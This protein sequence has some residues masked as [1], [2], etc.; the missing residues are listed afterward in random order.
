[1]N[2][3]YPVQ[4]YFPSNIVSAIGEHIL[5]SP[6]CPYLPVWQCPP[7]FAR[8]A[9]FSL[10]FQYG[11][12]LPYLTDWQCFPYFSVW[13]C[14][15]IFARLAV[16]SHVCHFGSV[17]PYFPDWQG[18]PMF[19]SLVVSSH[20]CQTGSDIPYLPVWQCPLIFAS[21]VVSSHICRTGSDLL[22]GQQPG[23]DLLAGT[24]SS[25]AFNLYGTYQMK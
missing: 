7:N 16:F 20:I 9:V 14:P 25:H 15:P 19:D 13:Q 2:G 6:R 24:C 10:I 8:L 17:F 21:L 1:M 3:A 22:S 18:S 12:V 5:K 4:F 11:S 23:P